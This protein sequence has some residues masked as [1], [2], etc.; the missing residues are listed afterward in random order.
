MRS[1][2]EVPR[3]LRLAVMDRAMVQVLQ[4]RLSERLTATGSRS[5]ETCVVDRR[6]HGP[7]PCFE[8]EDRITQRCSRR[9]VED[10][11]AVLACPVIVLAGSDRGEMPLHI[12]D[13]QH[14]T[15]ERRCVGARRPRER[16]VREPCD[17]RRKI[18]MA[19]VCRAEHR[20]D[21]RWKVARWLVLA[22]EHM[23]A[24]RT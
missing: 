17:Q 23:F 10:V 4:Q 11:A 5:F 6:K 19:I 7:H 18:F 9:A 24:A 1:L 2:P 8:I 22:H 15:G 21:D 13:V 20:A 16:I 12:Q 3:E 14:E